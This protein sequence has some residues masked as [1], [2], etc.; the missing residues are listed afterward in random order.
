[1]VP[2]VE[3]P[4]LK[5]M[6]PPFAAATLVGLPDVSPLVRTMLEPAP[7]VVAPTPTLIAPAW[8]HDASPVAKKIEPL[9]PSFED[10]APVDIKICPLSLVVEEAD[11]VKISI[12]PLPS[13]FELAAWV[14]K[15]SFPEKPDAEEPLVTM[16]APPT[17]PLPVVSPALRITAPPV[18]PALSPTAT[19]KLPAV[20]EV[21][22]PVEML[23]LPDGAA[24]VPVLRTISPESALTLPSPVRKSRSPE[25]SEPTVE[26]AEPVLITISPETPLLLP[27]SAVLI[28]T[29]PEEVVVPAPLTMLTEPP[30]ERLDAPPS[31]L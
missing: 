13:E 10:D 17:A 7:L 15:V 31:M 16:T 29:S 28:F 21:E 25:A 18:P 27:L 3:V 14:F 24:A 19:L 20:L 23:I 1:M 6:L 30:V 11:P 9:V 2:L 4:V 8:P 26:E 22:S 5:L 12:S